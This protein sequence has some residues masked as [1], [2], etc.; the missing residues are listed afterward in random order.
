MSF[1]KPMW[2]NVNSRAFDS[3]PLQWVLRV[4]NHK[5][6]RLEFPNVFLFYVI[7]V[8]V[9][10]HS[11]QVTEILP[12]PE[13]A[14]H[15]APQKVHLQVTVL[16]FEEALRTNLG[17]TGVSAPGIT[18]LWVTARYTSFASDEGRET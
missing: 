16:S 7:A 6:T 13:L 4:I 8:K 2:R 12:F 11:V 9:S 5:K 3:R 10:P 15:F 17:F 18:F 1:R 14:L